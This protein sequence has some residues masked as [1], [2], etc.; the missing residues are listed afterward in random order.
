MRDKVWKK[1]LISIVVI[2]FIGAG[3]VPC[4]SGTFRVSVEQNSRGSD[5]F[6]S[7]SIL[8]VGGSGPGNYSNIQ[9]AIDNASNGDT[10]FVYNDSSPYYETISIDQSINLVGEDRD[11]TIIDGNLRGD[12]ITISVDW[13]NI[14]GFTIRNGTCGIIVKSKHNTITENNIFSNNGTGI[15]LISSDY[16]IITNN[17]CSLNHG[18]GISLKSTNNCTIKGNLLSDNKG[19]YSFNTTGLVG[20]WKMDEISWNGTLGEVT[21]SSGNGNNGTAQNGANTTN[22]SMFGRAGEFDGDDDYVE[23]FD[24]SSL[25]LDTYFTVEAW[26]Y[27]RTFPHPSNDHVPI[28]WRGDKIG[29]GSDYHFRIAQGN[30]VGSVTWG[31]GGQNG[32]EYYFTA[33]YIETKK[34]H[35]FVYVAD[36]SDLK[37]Y[38]DGEYVGGRTGAPPYNVAGYKTYCGKGIT[39]EGDVFTDGI[40]DEVKIYNRSLSLEEIK[41]HY[42]QFIGC[43]GI[44]LVQSNNNSIINNTCMKNKEGI[45]ISI[46]NENSIIN[47]SI[48]YNKNG[49][50][51]NKCS[52]KNIIERNYVW[53]NNYGVLVNLADG[54][55]FTRNK[56][57][58]KGNIIIENFI[59]SNSYCG[60]YFNNFSDYNTIT[61]NTIWNN[62]ISIN[63]I[64]SN[65]NIITDNTLTNSSSNQVNMHLFS[66]HNNTISYNNIFDHFWSYGLHLYNSSGNTI[67]DN[68]ISTRGDFCIFFESSDNNSVYN[69]TLSATWSWH[70]IYLEYSRG[71]SIFGNN[72]SS[73]GSDCGIYLY[74]SSNTLVI[75]NCLSKKSYYGY[76]GIYIDHSIN[77]TLIGNIVTQNWNDGIR[78]EYSSNITIARNTISNNGNGLLLRYSPNTV[79]RNNTLVNNSNNFGVE[80]SEI[81]HYYHDIDTTN[82]INGKPIYYLL[83]QHDIVINESKSIGYLSLV[84]CR[85]MT[86]MNRQFFNEGNE[87]LLIN[88]SYSRLSNLTFN[89]S[90][91]CIILRF[92]CNNHITNCTVY[93]GYNCGVHLSSSNNNTLSYNT[94]FIYGWDGIFLEDSNDN[95]IYRNEISGYY[96]YNGINVESSNNNIIIKNNISNIAYG[97]YGIYVY[98]SNNN[99]LMH[100]AVVDNW[101]KAMYFYYSNNNILVGNMIQENYNGVILKSA[102]NNV[103]RNNTISNNSNNFGV[104]GYDIIH[105]YQDV[106][107]SNTINGKPIYYL[108]EQSNIIL[109]ESIRIGY[110]G[111]ISCSNITIQNRLFTNIEDGL[112]LINTSYSTF[113]NLTI[114]GNS[115]HG[116]YL[117]YS[118]NHNKVINCS[119]ENN[120]DDGINVNNCIGNVIT[121]NTI[122]KNNDNG[123]RLEYS[124]KTVLAQNIITANNDYGIEMRDSPD[125]TLIGNTIS[126]NNYYGIYFYDSINNLVKDNHLF[127]NRDG[128][129]FGESTNIIIVGNHIKRNDGYGIY[130]DESINSTIMDNTISHN[131]E[132]IKFYRS[133]NNIIKE[134][135]IISNAKYGITI[136]RYSGSNN[137]TGNVIS[138]NGE[139]IL[140]WETVGN[141]ITKNT[142]SSNNRCGI[143]LQTSS[144]NTIKNNTLASNNGSGLYLNISYS[145][146]ITNNCIDSNKR[147][148]IYG[149]NRSCSNTIMDN[150]CTSNNKHGIFLHYY[151]NNNQILHNNFINNEENAHDD[152]DNTWDDGKF[153]NYWSDYEERYP[154]AKKKPLKGIWDTPYEI[155]GG[156]N[157]DTC[158]LVNKWPDPYSFIVSKEQSTQSNSVVPIEAKPAS[159]DCSDSKMMP[160]HKT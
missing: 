5:V 126:H 58:S 132:G 129:R 41:A 119:I 2:V 131:N 42:N 146:T 7:R 118:S 29:W 84:S 160:N 78:I 55:D 116:V 73:M 100:N 6:I 114:Y 152:C 26:A 52:Y 8:H 45:N 66:S 33:G 69:N 96:L 19:R 79:M 147:S 72:V 121:G 156:K 67:N 59:S 63:L 4:I 40:I 144:I 71:N 51:V 97:D 112:F 24:S 47:N 120:Q 64:S 157:R 75:N 61:N 138:N 76:N 81:I 95:T 107:T 37:A 54:T 141:L 1:T 30:G 133:R 110:V 21:D 43:I 137:V 15:Y 140:L 91:I 83:E 86:I 151:S 136:D 35:H 158:P 106:D 134:N 159:P 155:L 68:C 154:D 62:G 70:I 99:T 27:I 128:I 117:Y 48:T 22:F 38:I 28:V 18:H 92:S 124:N 11:T 89:N 93:D 20:Y 150:N 25:Q 153:G 108:V 23:I 3:I 39:Y 53:N 44:Y 88:T 74:S 101:N 57:P 145:N 36:G 104:E 49:I 127:D 56:L 113:K 85:N 31:S 13:V 139:G 130:S 17:N 115:N 50:S 80:G 122:T 16:N 65:N 87:L 143:Y 123:I 82:T 12:A 148:G 149:T 125:N 90:G 46:S 103:L 32:V 10:I 77:I 135:E 60:I 142:L 109:N 94:I 111:L 105:Y 102:P 98:N 14:S 34:W 9:D